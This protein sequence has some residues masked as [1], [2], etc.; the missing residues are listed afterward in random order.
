MLASKKEEKEEVKEQKMAGAKCNAR[1]LV[2][3]MWEE[4]EEQRRKERSGGGWRLGGKKKK[5]IGRAYRKK[6]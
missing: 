1:W 6:I 4:W 2:D 5:R 3:R